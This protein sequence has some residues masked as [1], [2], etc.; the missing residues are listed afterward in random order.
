MGVGSGCFLGLF[1]GR[2]QRVF[3]QQEMYLGLQRWPAPV[4][5]WQ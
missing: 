1:G 4:A 3:T 5:I 2:D